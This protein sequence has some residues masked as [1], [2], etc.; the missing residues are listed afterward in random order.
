MSGEGSKRRAR[1]QDSP[2]VDTEPCKRSRV[3]GCIVA[4]QVAVIQSPAALA[5]SLS[6]SL[7]SSCAVQVQALVVRVP[8]HE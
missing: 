7:S 5:R 2:I 4:R 3:R 1:R 8:T 6:L